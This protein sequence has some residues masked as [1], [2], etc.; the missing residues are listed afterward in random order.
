[1]KNDD[2]TK[3][4]DGRNREVAHVV[5][6]RPGPGMDWTEEGARKVALEAVEKLGCAAGYFPR[7]SVGI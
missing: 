2:D 3:R 1:M 5:V 7:S 4:A 6:L